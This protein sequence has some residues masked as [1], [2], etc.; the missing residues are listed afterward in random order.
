MNELGED[1]LCSEDRESL[2]FRLASLIVIDNYEQGE[3]IHRNYL[4]TLGRGGMD[5]ARTDCLSL[6]PEGCF[7]L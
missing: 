5:G 1:S 2:L 3:K 4:Q 6:L 7:K